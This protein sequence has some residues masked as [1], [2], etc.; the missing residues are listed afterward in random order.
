MRI[1]HLVVMFGLASDALLAQSSTPRGSAAGNADSTKL[2]ESEPE[3]R[4]AYGV[5]GGA[6]TFPDGRVQQSLGALFRVRLGM[7]VSI[8]AT[9][10]T[11]HMQYPTAVGGGSA[12]GLTDMPVELD[13]DHDIPRTPLSV[14]A[15]LGASAPVGDTATG[16]GSGKVGYSISAGANY[17][18]TDR[19]SFHVGSG[20][21][22]S[23]FTFGSPLG[24]SSSS[25]AEAETSVQLTD[26]VGVSLN[27]DGDLAGQ[28]SLG[29][30][31][32]VGAGLSIALV[33]PT[34]LTLTGS[35]GVSGAAARWT[36]AVGIGT[37]FAWIGSIASTSPMQRVIGALGVRSHGNGHG[38]RTETPRKA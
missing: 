30:S 23:N 6:M 35:H 26:R 11:A 3:G 5:T 18:A 27:V 2:D 29:A 34:T 4:F 21:P 20:R 32:A 25:W 9:P 19:L 38:G 22:L 17:A 31:R 7:G 13:V 1:I 15:A 16:F 36:T 14:G 8:A 33:G 12:S 24:S 28:D 37:D 10:A